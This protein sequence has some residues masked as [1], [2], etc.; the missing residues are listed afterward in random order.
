VRVDPK[1]AELVELEGRLARGQ[2]ALK[3]LISKSS[4]DPEAWLENPELR[5]FAEQLPQL[6]AEIEAVRREGG[7]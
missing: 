7:P 6:Q 1:R 2:E 4:T 3:E 5:E